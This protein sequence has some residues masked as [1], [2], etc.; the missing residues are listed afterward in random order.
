MREER[1][2]RVDFG[3]GKERSRMLAR[4]EYMVGLEGEK[5]S[6]VGIKGNGGI[7]CTVV[8]HIAKSRE[9]RLG[10]SIDSGMIENLTTLENCRRQLNV[11][12]I[13]VLVTK[14]KSVDDDVL[15]LKKFAQ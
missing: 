14:Q 5:W 15:N 7:D 9:E 4:R 3:A 1:G 10:Q 8:K 6:Q 13:W 2:R 12:F 11:Q